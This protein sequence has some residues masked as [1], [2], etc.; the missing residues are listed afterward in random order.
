MSQTGTG[1]AKGS[2]HPQGGREET[3]VPEQGVW[4]KALSKKAISQLE[5]P[6]GD[7]E[8]VEAGAREDSLLPYDAMMQIAGDGR[9]F[10]SL[11]VTA[12]GQRF[13]LEAADAEMWVTNIRNYI[14]E[15]GRALTELASVLPVK[16]QLLIDGHQRG[17][18]AGKGWCGIL[19]LMQAQCVNQGYDFATA[20]YAVDEELEDLPER[21][22]AFLGAI[23]VAGTT[24]RKLR[25]LQELV[26]LP[27]PVLRKELWLQT[28]DELDL[29]EVGMVSW[30]VDNGFGY[31]LHR[32]AAGHGG[33][34]IYTD[35]G[36]VISAPAIAY[37]SEH[38]FICTG[39]TVVKGVEDKFLHF[40]KELVAKVKGM[41]EGSIL[42][43]VAEIKRMRESEALALHS[44]AEPT[45]LL[46][47]TIPYEVRWDHE[48]TLRHIEAAVA[49]QTYVE[50]RTDCGQAEGSIRPVELQ[51]VSVSFGVII[52]CRRDPVYPGGVIPTHFVATNMEARRGDGDRTYTRTYHC[53]TLTRDQA[54]ALT[55]PKRVVAI[56][57]GCTRMDW[58]DE[59]MR[60]A[61]VQMI[62]QK[63]LQNCQ[64]VVEQVQQAISLKVVRETIVVV[65]EDLLQPAILLEES[66]RKLGFTNGKTSFLTQIRGLGFQVV[67]DAS[68]LK[69]KRIPRWV[70]SDKRHATISNVHLDATAKDV[71]MAVFKAF[72][73]M[74][75]EYW[76]V[77]RAAKAQTVVVALVDG[78]DLVSINTEPL[79]LIQAEGRVYQ[80]LDFDKVLTRK[81]ETL[82]LFE[83]EERQGYASSSS[84]SDRGNNTVH[85]GQGAQDQRGRGKS[86]NLNTSQLSYGGKR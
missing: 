20:R 4:T 21:V 42:P 61:V 12:G 82:Q 71:M 76:F 39:K 32:T 17:F 22:T 15:G 40:V 79:Q 47:S 68:A 9:W 1:W 26:A 28:D 19:A 67:R 33:E 8:E 30:Y 86:R 81:E 52:E 46:I 27:L 43:K 2:L 25:Q 53:Q 85:L 49:N 16:V 48:G 69:G 65:Y 7:G 35:I 18:T 77:R 5:S 6:L 55:K 64:V 10:G 11:M 57:R 37:A 29:S 63:V 13:G 44:M 31:W 45:H 54:L 14:I 75:V 24:E 72:G 66:R 78:Y 3:K 62:Q 58:I 70:L 41:R 80:Y 38:F 23:K 74:N 73:V 59:L 34:L 83:P 50:V 60:S 56:F 84:S 36:D 51:D